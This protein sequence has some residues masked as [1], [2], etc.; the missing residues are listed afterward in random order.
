[1][2]E[3]K[4][5]LVFRVGHFQSIL[6]NI[7]VIVCSQLKHKSLSCCLIRFHITCIVM[8]LLCSFEC[9]SEGV[10][11]LCLL[12]IGQSE[13]IKFLQKLRIWSQ[14]R[15]ISV[16]ICFTTVVPLVTFILISWCD[17]NSIYYFDTSN[18]FLDWS[19]LFLRLQIS[20]FLTQIELVD[21]GESES[22]KIVAVLSMACVILCIE[23]VT[24]FYQAENF[25]LILAITLLFQLIVQ[26]VS[27]FF[28]AIISIF[29]FQMDFS[30]KHVLQSMHWFVGSCSSIPCYFL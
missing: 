19:N 24:Y 8:V 9:F 13:S 17:G 26:F 12:I 11:D 22:W 6:V 15:Y 2:D 1:M 29:W 25:H 30:W 3:L 27:Q 23:S 5:S 20:S 18:V 10:M 14:M 21:W 4:C 16:E 7:H 28:H